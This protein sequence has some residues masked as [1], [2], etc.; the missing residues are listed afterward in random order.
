MFPL[1]LYTVH[2]IAYIDIF[3]HCEWNSVNRLVILAQLTCKFI[4]KSGRVLAGF[5]R[6]LSSRTDAEIARIET[7]LQN[8]VASKNRVTPRYS[9]Y[10]CFCIKPRKTV[11]RLAAMFSQLFMLHAHNIRVCFVCKRHGND[12]A[13]LAWA[14]QCALRIALRK[15]R[16]GSHFNTAVEKLTDRR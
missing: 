12:D 6:A 5:A 8:I 11:H 14:I 10:R 7:N 3:S 4:A 9:I 13:Y 15:T 2:V 1:F 16:R